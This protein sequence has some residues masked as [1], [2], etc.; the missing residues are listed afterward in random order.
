MPAN[1]R[2]DPYVYVCRRQ[3]TSS[4]GAGRA[5]GQLGRRALSQKAVPINTYVDRQP[6]YVRV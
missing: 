1:V 6:P 4:P 3:S 2:I 5:L